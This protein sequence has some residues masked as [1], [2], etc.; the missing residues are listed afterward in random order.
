MVGIGSRQSFGFMQFVHASGYPHPEHYYLCKGS[1]PHLWSMIDHYEHISGSDVC[2][3]NLCVYGQPIDFMANQP[4][5]GINHVYDERFRRS[6]GN[7]T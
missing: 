5:M 6:H 3:V 2:A 7:M 1:T 4:E